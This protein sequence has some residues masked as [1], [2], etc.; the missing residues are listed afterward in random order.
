MKTRGD[1]LS[2][3]FSSS[4]FSC[5]SLRLLALY[6]PGPYC[7]PQREVKWQEAPLLS[8]VCFYFLFCFLYINF[9]LLVIVIFFA[10]CCVFLPF[11]YHIRMHSPPFTTVVI[12]HVTHHVTAFDQWNHPFMLLTYVAKGADAEVLQRREPVLFGKHSFPY[13]KPPSPFS[14]T[15]TWNF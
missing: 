11:T 9:F 12:F 7:G 2:F 6:Y 14:L 10:F 4:I 3:Y 15:L 1:L 13:L 5:W 8:F